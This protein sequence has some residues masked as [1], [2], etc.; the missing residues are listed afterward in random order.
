ME[1][2]TSSLTSSD[3]EQIT[4]VNESGNPAVL[5]VHG[6]WLLA[7]SWNPWRELFEASGYATIAPGWPGD[8]ASVEEAR[9]HPEVFAGIGIADVADRYVE[10]IK[11]LSVKPILVGHSFGGLIVQKLAGWGLAGVTVA[12]DPAPFRG[13]LPLPYSSIKAA[14]PVLANP[15]NVKRSVMLSYLQFRYAFANAVPESE[16]QALYETYPVPGSGRPL[17]QAAFANLN[18]ASEA[19]VNTAN[20]LRG[21][22]KI[23]S[24][25][26]DLTVP[27]AI[28]EA[29]F[30]RQ[31][32]NPGVTEIE[33]I[34]GRGHS[35]IL[36]SGW[37]D[38]AHSAKT[39][40]DRFNEK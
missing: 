13:V 3:L 35:L 24:G 2:Q 4:R 26:R 36:D 11:A 40:I 30:K 31:R 6:L 33:L 38:V 28:A 7:D 12:I 27:W 22:L 29:S 25:E 8:P 21:P 32:R 34:T 17:F 15:V 5:F 20:P 9:A 23:I 18:P 19:R 10:I 16:A 14:S 37:L 1:G 39:F